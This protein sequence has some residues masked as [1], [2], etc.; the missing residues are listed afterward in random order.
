M[1][2]TARLFL[3]KTASVGRSC[4][5]WCGWTWCGWTWCGWTW[6][7]YALR[8]KSR[9]C[10]SVDLCGGPNVCEMEQTI[11]HLALTAWETK[12]QPGSQVDAPTAIGNPAHR[13]RF[14]ELVCTSRIETKATRSRPKS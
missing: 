1:A 9:E 12:G 5:P 6:C 3:R 10:S 4:S 7:G 8:Q 14:P 11:E 13:G 2:R